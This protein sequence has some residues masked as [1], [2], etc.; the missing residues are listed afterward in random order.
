M[1]DSLKFDRKDK[2]KVEFK[3]GKKPSTR[4][5]VMKKPAGANDQIVDFGS[6]FLP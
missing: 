2:W 6:Q 1:L 5:K 3:N 4:S